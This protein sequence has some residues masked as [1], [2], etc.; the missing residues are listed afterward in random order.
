[1]NYQ[2]NCTQQFSTQLNPTDNP[3]E[4]AEVLHTPD[5]DDV[6]S[7]AANSI[8]SAEPRASAALTSPIETA[9]CVQEPPPA[10]PTTL[11]RRTYRHSPAFVAWVLREI[12]DS[13][14]YPIT[15]FQGVKHVRHLIS[16]F[17]SQS[18]F[19]AIK[20][21][22]I[23]VLQHGRV[24]V[25]TLA[26][27][28]N[29]KLLASG[30]D[31]Y[32]V[33]LWKVADG[34]LTNELKG[35]T[36]RVARV[37]FCPN[38]EV[39]ASAA[40]DYTVRLWNV[41]AGTLTQTINI[42]SYQSCAFSPDWK[43]FATGTHDKL[44]IWNV[45]GGTLA[46]TLK[47]H[48]NY[49]SSISFSPDGKMLAT[50]SMAEL[51]LWNVE[52]GTRVKAL[53]GH[54]RWVSSLAFS[55]DGQLLAAAAESNPVRLWNVAK[56]TQV[57]TVQD[58]ANWFSRVAFSTDGKLL[59]SATQKNNVCLWNVRDGKLAKTLEGHTKLITDVTFSPDG[60]LLASASDLGSIC[61]WG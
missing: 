35:H 24:C 60:Q 11:N 16:L 51:N 58:C 5:T 36:N 8:V 1:M 48:Q 4:I 13:A 18:N 41:A 59:A 38:G 56:G 26:F 45:A 34:T 20:A 27:S 9:K 6:Q 44:L 50:G 2:L 52:D 19:N 23:R 37:A 55:P 57:E 42:P 15:V 28:P 25:N 32:R 53:Q 3:N 30:A 21:R 43:Q 49:L 33:C 47:R 40:R 12:R 14:N 31:D 22:Q 7:A 54:T 10:S 61:L 46:K 39:L 17:A 29:S